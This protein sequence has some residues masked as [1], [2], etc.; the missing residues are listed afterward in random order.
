MSERWQSSQL[1]KNKNLQKNDRT[2]RQEQEQHT[3][4]KVSPW[5]SESTMIISRTESQSASTTTNTAIW[6]RNVGRRRKKKPESASNA[7]E[8]DIL[9]RTVKK[10]S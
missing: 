9:S 3:E 10:N 4:G 6:P 8:R 1:D 7:K 2:T 5:T